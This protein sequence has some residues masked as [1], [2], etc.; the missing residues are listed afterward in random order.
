MTELVLWFVKSQ[1]TSQL[2]R[3]LF[4]DCSGAQI[5]AIRGKT[6]GAY[7][8]AGL[9][10]WTHGRLRLAKAGDLHVDSQRRKVDAA[11]RIAGIKLITF[12]QMLAKFV[13]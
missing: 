1:G 9:F 4:I 10:Q 8:N 13:L 5:L 11:G 2:E 7:R 6:N 3:T 12:K